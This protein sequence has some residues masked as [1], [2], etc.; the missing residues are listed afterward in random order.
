MHGIILLIETFFLLLAY[1]IKDI[2]NMH[3]NLMYCIMIIGVFLAGSCLYLSIFDYSYLYVEDVT[4]DSY[5][6][7]QDYEYHTRSNVQPD[8]GSEKVSDE[9]IQNIKNKIKEY[10][11]KIVPFV[12]L[13]I[14]AFYIFNFSLIKKYCKNLNMELY[15]LQHI[16]LSGKEL[17]NIIVPI[18]VL[19]DYTYV[20]YDICDY[21]EEQLQQ[22][23]SGIYIIL[24]NPGEGKTVAIRK[25]SDMLLEKWISKWNDN[26]RF[27][28]FVFRLHTLKDEKT[29]GEYIP[30]IINFVDIKKITELSELYKYIRRQFFAIANVNYIYKS[31]K[32]FKNIDHIIVNRIK[33]GKFI[34]LFDGLDEVNEEA[35]YD[36]IKVIEKLKKKFPKCILVLSSRTAVFENSNYFL[37]NENIL[38]LVPF[39]KEKIKRFLSYWD[40][41]EGKFYWELY[42][43]IINNYQ[44]ERLAENPL[45][46]TLMS[47]LYDN[48]QLKSPNSITNF[49][50]ESTRCLLEN[51]ESE[52]RIIKRTKIDYDI[53]DIFLQ[54]IAYYIYRSGDLSFTKSQIMKETKDIIDYG[55]NQQSI[56]NEIYLYSGIL[57]KTKDGL[58]TFCHRSFYEFFLAEYFVRYKMEDIVQNN[59][60][61]DYQIILFYLALSSNSILTERYIENNIDNIS[62]IDSLIL[63]CKIENPKLIKK[64]FN[65]IINYQ[66]NQS[67]KFYQKLSNLAVKF[68]FIE[69]DVY[70]YLLKQLEVSIEN[71]RSD[72]ILYIIREI[73]YFA[74]VDKVVDIILKYKED[75]L[76]NKLAEDS[77][78]QLEPSFILLFN[79]DI[80]QEYKMLLIRGLCNAGKFNVILDILKHLKN[81]KDKKIIF[82]EFLFL[83]KE[84]YFIQWFDQQDLLCFVD[85]DVIKIIKEWKKILIGSGES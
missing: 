29:I 77:N 18:N 75:V 67:A 21:F 30:V 6:Y 9:V 56:F 58:Y 12:L 42:E 32:I 52:K 7:N 49:Y 1:L 44:L 5:K 79:S 35:R 73:S 39:S 38:F 26:H 50:M 13:F 78:L 45:L 2:R 34:L 23:Q 40:F 85:E 15:D 43:R 84:R 65:N 82:Y 36:L 68:D 41:S 57:L 46:L 31:K 54:K 51:W 48:S 60:K 69:K 63:E 71:Q 81:Q 3:R 83:T 28:N 72:N 16:W 47:Y 74:D 55:I 14:L 59:R 53:K 61:Q 27:S 62:L 76:F 70:D 64:Y 8:H 4:I 66:G 20:N 10:A 17:R 11:G 19:H 22:N 80:S 37:M 24:G 25:V 33:E